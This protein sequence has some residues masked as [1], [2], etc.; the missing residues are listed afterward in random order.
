MRIRKLQ[1]QILL[2]WSDFDRKHDQ[3]VK[4]I[5]GRIS[6]S[7]SGITAKVGT[8]AGNFYSNV[9]D[10]LPLGSDKDKQNLRNYGRESPIGSWLLFGLLM[11]ILILFLAWLPIAES[12]DFR[13]K[14]VL[15]V[16]NVLLTLSIFILMSFSLNLHTGYTGMVN[17]GAIA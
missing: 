11:F 12:D 16:S 13:F 6:Q 10:K 17:F 5:R 2:R 4:H 1:N 14:K 15:Q 3:F 7:S 8:K 9:L